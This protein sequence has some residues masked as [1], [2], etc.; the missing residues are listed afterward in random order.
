MAQ[1][2][3]TTSL[4]DLVGSDRVKSKPR[5]RGGAKAPDL[6]RSDLS[7]HAPAVWTQALRLDGGGAQKE[8]TPTAGKRASDRRRAIESDRFTRHDGGVDVSEERQHVY[9]RQAAA[10]SSAFGS[11][12]SIDRRRIPCG[13]RPPKES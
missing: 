4:D 8:P 3:L 9:D 1:C 11:V 13:G 7:G 5:K 10:P 2:A 12:T 6:T